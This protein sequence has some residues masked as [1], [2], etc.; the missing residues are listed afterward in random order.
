MLSNN[1]VYCSW[2]I[3]GRLQKY[4][5][6]APFKSKLYTKIPLGGLAEWVA[7]VAVWYGV[8]VENNIEI[9]CLSLL[10]YSEEIR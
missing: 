9:T 10:H 2:S 6:F 7:G 5:Y 4:T 1:Y 3:N 8:W